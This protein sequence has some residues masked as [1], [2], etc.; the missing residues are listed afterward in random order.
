MVNGVTANQG[1]V[2]ICIFGVWGTVC[3]DDWDTNNNNAKVVCRQLG[4]NT[5]GELALYLLSLV[6][7]LIIVPR[8]NLEYAV[9]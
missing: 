6:F 3:D 7:I 8:N 5:D 4:Y 2:E 9:A 1:R